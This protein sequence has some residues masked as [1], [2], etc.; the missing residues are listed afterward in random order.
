MQPTLASQEGSICPRGK[1]A[2][3]LDAREHLVRCGTYL[4]QQ[5][6]SGIG[7]DVQPACVGSLP[8]SQW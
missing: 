4:A 2:R 8:G 5:Y 1:I 3:S 6:A 7:N